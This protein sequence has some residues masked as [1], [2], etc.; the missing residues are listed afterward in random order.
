MPKRN[1]SDVTPQEQQPKRKAWTNHAASI[2][3]LMMTAMATL[4]G[5][6][7][8]LVSHA[9]YY[10]LSKVL[11]ST[12]TNYTRQQLA[13]NRTQKT[14]RETATA[15]TVVPNE[16]LS[17]PRQPRYPN[18]NDKFP[19]TFM[20]NK[21]YLLGARL[22]T[23]YDKFDESVS[24]DMFG[25][26]VGEGAAEYLGV[27]KMDQGEGFSYSEASQQRLFCRLH[28][29]NAENVTFSSIRN[30]PME[31]IPTRTF[32]P[33]VAN[34]HLIWRCN[35]SPYISKTQIRQ[36][37]HVRVTVYT[38]KNYFH[39]NARLP[40]LTVDV[41]IDTATVGYAGPLVKSSRVTSF[42]EKVAQE[43][44]IGVMLCVAGVQ[45]NAM[46]YLP[47]WI[48]HHLNVGI[49]H[50][51]IGVH[52]KDV[53]PYLT[54]KLAYYIERGVVVLGY[55]DEVMPE[56]EIRKLRAYTQC[57]YH[58][59]GMSEY[60]V[61]WD[62]DEIWMPPFQGDKAEAV[63]LVPGT[64]HSHVA[65]HFLRRSSQVIANL[66]PDEE[67]LLMLSPYPNTMSLIEAVR[68]LQGENGCTN[69]CFQTFPSYT[70]LRAKPMITDA[71]HPR[72]QGFYGHSVREAVVNYV[73]QKPVIQTKYAH[74]ASYHLGGSCS[75]AN[76]YS[77][78][79]TE[80]KY[81]SEFPDCP[82]LAEMRGTSLGQMHHFDM[83][84]RDDGVVDTKKFPDYDEYTHHFRRTVIQQLVALHDKVQAEYF[85]E[86]E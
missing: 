71:I 49:D 28:E 81:Q 58:A 52:F 55:E 39:V 2:A 30:V 63:A 73:W 7:S 33:N 18:D 4:F 25:H 14:T 22:T 24:F 84:F 72:K 82:L 54:E 69:W 40:L 47:E 31:Y 80:E 35:L 57:L 11:P 36:L 62:I 29:D 16:A 78:N 37:T 32:D 77:M 60:L 9:Q 1:Y 43:G 3:F 10:D 15:G 51:F 79:Y 50:I 23:S 76:T 56:G 41:P 26:A 74:Q 85:V 20:Q 83:T 46:F 19:G 53:L 65:R 13:R 38:R 66:N 12:S 45:K 61:I 59:K 42:I 48:Q 64:N 86:A 67:K 70:V 34:A 68:S 44:P 17:E 27:S 8:Q 6:R 5:N 75:R 21:L